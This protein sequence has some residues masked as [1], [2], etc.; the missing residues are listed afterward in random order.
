VCVRND[1][2]PAS[3]ELRK[4]YPI[5]PGAESE[6]HGMLRAVDESGEDYLYPRDWFV[7]T[8]PC[9]ELRAALQ[10]VSARPVLNRASMPRVE[11]NI[12]CVQLRERGLEGPAQPGRTLSL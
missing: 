6:R 4:I 11:V 7:A 12:L 9:E 2:V 1:E 3:L 10:M 5:I 8:D